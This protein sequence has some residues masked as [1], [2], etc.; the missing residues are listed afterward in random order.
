MFARA[1]SIALPA[2]LLKMVISLA[3]QIVVARLLLPDG[4][5]IYA[6]CMATS[7]VLLV[8]TY[9]GNEFG[10]RYLLV[11]KRIT[12]AQAFRY[13]LLTAAFSLAF[14]LGL[15]ALAKVLDLRTTSE[16]TLVQLM[17]AC[18]L[19]FSQLVSTQLNVFMTIR[20]E[21]FQASILTIL[22]E[23][24]KLVAVVIMMFNSPTVEVALSSAILGNL[25]I[26]TFSVIRYKFYIR[27][28]VAI[29][30]RDIRFIYRYGMRSFP[31]N[32]SNISNAHMGTLVLSGIMSNNQIGIYN[33]AF[34][35]IA[36][37]QVLPDT[38]NRVLVPASMASRDEAGRFG[39]VQISVTG[40]LAFSLLA[41]PALALLNEPI[42]IILFGR[43][44][45]AAGPIASFLAI[46]FSFKIIAKPLEA[47]FNEI[48]G[49]PKVI[50]V[51]QVFGSAMMAL[52][53]YLGAIWIGL[54][55]A[56]IGSSIALFLGA[57][58]LFLAYSR[59]T[60][61]AVSSIV[62]PKALALRLR[63]C[64]PSQ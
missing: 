48:A 54:T 19:S 4:R 38:L 34:S 52:L 2:Q 36:R 63:Q 6:T 20:R 35:L 45:A 21:Y 50:A 12:S 24:V 39:M 18:L 44:Y 42:I 27:D 26:T 8:L 16:I 51:I 17:L 59:S 11:R 55:G 62:N 33:I 13:L 15:C 40:L 25:I 5:G 43:D 41:V 9:F 61:R 47:H 29:R 3:L 7:T 30:V 53:T 31:L 14:A 32:L 37:L 46:G 28:F 22:E 49:N 1:L 57:T 58:A 60:K 10:I 64:G 56:S 23:I